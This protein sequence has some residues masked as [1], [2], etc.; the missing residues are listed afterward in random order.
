LQQLKYFRHF[1][2]HTASIFKI[3]TARVEGKMEGIRDN[4]F[5]VN[6]KLGRAFI[7]IQAF[8]KERER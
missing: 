5:T 7:C 3:E 2:E 8:Q 4:I 1:L 6:W